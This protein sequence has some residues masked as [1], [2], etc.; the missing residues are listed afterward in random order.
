MSKMS[1]GLGGE[2]GA[3]VAG[4]AMVVALA[5]GA[6]IAF[7]RGADRL[8]DVPAPEGQTNAPA[9][10]ENAAI[11]KPG[12][13][14]SPAAPR[15][16]EL[17]RETDG[18]TIIA[19]RAA[20]LSDVK[21]M[22]DGAEIASTTADSTGGFATIAKLPQ[23]DA[24]Q[25]VTLSARNAQTGGSAAQSLD[26]IIL[27]PTK[28]VQQDTAPMPAET[29][30][31]ERMDEP[32]SVAVL[33]SDAEGVRLLNPA[34]TRA[35]TSVAL[36]TI[37]YT[38]QGDVQLTGRAQP[39][40]AKVRVYLDN[41]SVISLPVDASGRWQGDL[42]DVDEGVYTLRVDEVTASGTVSSRVETPF[43][44]ES[45][46]TLA[47]ASA[48]DGPVSSVTV[49]TGATLWAI[50]RERYGDGTLYVRV[51]EANQAS[52][53]NPDLIYPGQVFDLPN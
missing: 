19:G 44:R 24:A 7:G 20:P 21:I 14:I 52:I 38:D 5:L 2:A 30:A 37:G 12:A 51:F 18:T 49:Q 42:P 40:T 22:V 43:K 29:A 41:R 47:Q 25:V 9:L 23:R 1:A 13:V 16:D 39:D 10:S 31:P 17:R 15:F 32:A 8:S 4:G 33:K 53:R 27:A 6:Y 50:A 46:A 48:T 35:M 3:F 34:Q 26:E 11:E 36:D 28:P 45:A